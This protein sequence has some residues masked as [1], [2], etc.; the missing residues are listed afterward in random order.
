MTDPLLIVNN[1]N[2]LIADERIWLLVCLIDKFRENEYDGSNRKNPLRPPTLE[3]L[4][5]GTMFAPRRTHS[6]T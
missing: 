4:C 2:I 5:T 3:I 1:K 6:I